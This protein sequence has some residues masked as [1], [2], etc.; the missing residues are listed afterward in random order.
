MEIN[1]QGMLSYELSPLMPKS[2]Q[3]LISP[4][5]IA[6][7]SQIIVTGRKDI[8]NHLKCFWLFNKFSFLVTQEMC[9]E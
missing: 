9:R 7:E 1:K 6:P 3:H 5:N 4:S 8:I 2:D